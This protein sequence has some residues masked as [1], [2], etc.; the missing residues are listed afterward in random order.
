MASGFQASSVEIQGLRRLNATHKI[1]NKTGHTRAQCN[2]SHGASNKPRPN[3]QQKNGA[4]EPLVRPSVV[5]RGCSGTRSTRWTRRSSQAAGRTV[6]SGGICRLARGWAFLGWVRASVPGP[7]RPSCAS[8]W[9]PRTPQARGAPPDAPGGAWSGP[10]WC[11]GGG[12]QGWVN[13]GVGDMDE[14]LTGGALGW[15]TYGMGDRVSDWR[16][17]EWPTEGEWSAHLRQT[18]EKPLLTRTHASTRACKF[19]E[20]SLRLHYVRIGRTEVPLGAGV[21]AR[22]WMRACACVCSVHVLPARAVQHVRLLFL[23]FQVWQDRLAL[24]VCHHFQ[25]LVVELLCAYA[26]VVQLLLGS[27]MYAEYR[28]LWVRLQGRDGQRLETHLTRNKKRSS[29]RDSPERNTRWN[30]DVLGIRTQ[31]RVD[32]CFVLL[33]EVARR[34]QIHIKNG[35]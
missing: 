11:W 1:R 5:S 13:G 33:K 30:R 23:V 3:I 12:G 18:K 21:H 15:A 24:L 26:P 7:P 19:P 25:L 34:Q 32:H 14:W 16:E 27:V 29:W 6:C 20:R 9:W 4:V 35:W 2:Y 10:G 22:V 8:R 31:T 17:E 28:T